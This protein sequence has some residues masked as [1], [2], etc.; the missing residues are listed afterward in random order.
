MKEA[1]FNGNTFLPEPSTGNIETS[2]KS[3]VEASE[4]QMDMDNDD[5]LGDELSDADY[6]LV[7]VQKGNPVNVVNAASLAA[8]APARLS[9]AF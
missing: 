1:H 9:S 2:H 5:L 4:A 7:G 8:S 6:A 3:G